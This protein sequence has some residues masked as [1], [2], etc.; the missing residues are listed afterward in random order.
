VR[1]YGPSG[2]PDAAFTSAFTAGPA[3]LLTEG[4]V[5]AMALDAKGNIVCV[6]A[7]TQ[8][9]P[10]LTIARLLPGGGLDATFAGG[11]VRLPL[12]DGPL[13]SN[14]LG[15]ALQP[16]GSVLVV[17]SRLDA[18]GAEAGII[19]RFTSNGTRDA[20]FNG[21]VTI[22]IPA[23][24]FV[25][26]SLEASGAVLV[27][28]STISGALPS[29]FL[30]RR[31]SLGANDPTFGTAGTA[32]F[33]NTYRANAF[34]R[35]AD[36]SLALVGDVQ[37]GAAAYT[38]GVA[39]AKGDA[40]FARAFAS[41]PTAAFFGLAV[42]SD[43]RLIAAGHTAVV[44]GEAR[45]ERFFQDGGRDPSFSDGG[46][47]IV[48]PAGLSNALEVALFAAAVQSDGRILVAGN[49]STTGAVVYRLW[50]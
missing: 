36:G 42:Q 17:G 33:G 24:R 43:T 14:G 28:G 50:P 16:D 4:Q 23:T 25:G 34:A 3:P 27:A 6:G 7:S 26:A 49:R 10:A 48:E 8:P 11:I 37:Q 12:S 47:V 9:I 31:T 44:N 32:S 41:G 5:E 35:L 45:I 2:V 22:A 15:L 21:G 29:F 46:A 1:R 18:V 39:S 13:G 40:V 20:T 30:T 38:A 19:A